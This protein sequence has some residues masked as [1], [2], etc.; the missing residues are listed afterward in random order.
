MGRQPGAFVLPRDARLPSHLRS[1]SRIEAISEVRSGSPTGRDPIAKGPALEPGARI[2]RSPEWATLP[3][4]RGLL[5]SVL[6]VFIA[7][8]VAQTAGKPWPENAKWPSR[9]DG[10]EVA[11][12]PVFNEVVLSSDRLAGKFRADEIRLVLDLADG[13]A[14][15]PE[16]RN[17]RFIRFSATTGEVTVPPLPAGALVARSEGE[18]AATPPAIW[19]EFRPE[20]RFAV[21]ARIQRAGRPV[22]LAFAV[23]LRAAAPRTPVPSKLEFSPTFAPA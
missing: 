21:M 22:W 4:L 5:I 10:I 18:Y 12:K 1:K 11:L 20:E 14:F 3:L 6:T 15:V 23:S 17:I 16:P 19:Q 13:D 8:A 2:G 7:A 9:I